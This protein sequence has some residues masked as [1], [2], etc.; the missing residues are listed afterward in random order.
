M[1]LSRAVISPVL[2]KGASIWPISVVVGLTS[3]YI[4]YPLAERIEKRAIREKLKEL[5]KFYQLSSVEREKLSLQR[6][7][8]MVEF[9][10][11]QVPYYKD[12]FQQQG[13]NPENFYKDARYLNDV[14][15]L[16][17]DVIREQGERML[18]RP[19]N[20]IRHH[21]CKTGGS[22]GL[23]CHIYYDQVAADYSAAV[24]L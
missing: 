10:A 22:T 19:L 14:P 15:F 23:S 9:A 16:T 11:S 3:A 8:K 5:T 4:A 18:S 2:E 6:L 12:L 7:G 20:E 24:T 13:I 1:R 21:V 17:K